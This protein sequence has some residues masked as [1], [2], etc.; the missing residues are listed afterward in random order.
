MDS[1]DSIDQVWLW[2]PPGLILRWVLGPLLPGG[3]EIGA[4]RWTLTPSYAKAKNYN[5]TSIAPYALIACT[6]KF[7]FPSSIM[8]IS[9]FTQI[10]IFVTN[11]ILNNPEHF[12]THCVNTSNKDCLP[13]SL[14]SIADKKD[15]FKAALQTYLHT[16]TCCPANEFVMFQNDFQSLRNV[17]NLYI[18]SINVSAAYQRSNI[19][20]VTW[21]MTYSPSDFH[22]HKMQWMY[23]CMFHDRIIS[24]KGTL[25][26][27]SL[28]CNGR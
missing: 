4:L 14:K 12:H 17:C 13:P 28:D 21:W 18:I 6:G 26:I 5:Y 23:V 19:M 10:C 2:G 1:W 3:K 20:C 7:T 22:I 16:H 8:C 25:H 27:H 24:Q 15:K 11:F 9:I